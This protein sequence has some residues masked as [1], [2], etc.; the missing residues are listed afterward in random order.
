MAKIYLV[1]HGETAWNKEGLFQGQ[2]N[3]D[4]NE[5][6]I[7]QAEKLHDHL[8]GDKWDAVYCS[9]LK[10][11]MTTAQIIT[12][13]HNVELTPCTELREMNFGQLEGKNITEC[14]ANPVIS[15]WWENRDP[16]YAPPGGESIRQLAERSCQF[17]QRIN[18][19]SEE[20]IMIVAHGGTIRSL[21]CILMGLDTR[22]WWQ[23]HIDHTALSIIYATS[24]RGVIL[25][26]LNNTSHLN[27]KSG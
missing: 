18:L 26:L 11:A 10:R 20:N 7:K 9:D 14:F 27:G 25:S 5:T 24:Q 2:T 22:Y 13:R 21:I 4:L 16:D 15:K 19:Y 6:G 17:M 23:F 8:N 12:S 1:R 3:I